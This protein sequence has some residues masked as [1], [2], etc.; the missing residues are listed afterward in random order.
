MLW[1]EHAKNKVHLFDVSVS[2]ILYKGEPFKL[3]KGFAPFYDIS[4]QIFSE[5]KCLLMLNKMAFVYNIGSPVKSVWDLEHV[6][7]IN[8]NE[9]LDLAK[10]YESRLRG[11][12]LH[13]TW[14]VIG[15]KLFATVWDKVIHIWD[16]DIGLKLKEDS[17]MVGKIHSRCALFKTAKNMST[18]LVVAYSSGRNVLKCFVYDLEIFKFL[19]FN[20]NFKRK[21]VLKMYATD[22]FQNRCAIMDEVVAFC[23]DNYLTIYKYKTSEL[24]VRILAGDYMQVLDNRIYFAWKN[25]IIVFNVTSK[26]VEVLPP[27]KAVQDFEVICNKFLVVKKLDGS[28][29]V[30]ETDQMYDKV[31]GKPSKLTFLNCLKNASFLRFCIKSNRYFPLDKNECYLRRLFYHK[32][33]KLVIASFW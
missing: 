15:N 12:L 1:N 32:G 18:H 10:E 21:S 31:S 20:V 28:N 9:K 5:V 24:L 23:F 19:P 6:F 33:R 17:F 3:L 22:S 2:P 7:I 29:K 27:L 30:W 16:M 8:E 4:C 25:R 13:F 11:N 14:T 26:S